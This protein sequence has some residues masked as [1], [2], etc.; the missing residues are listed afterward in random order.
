MDIQQA[1]ALIEGGVRKDSH[2]WAD[3]GAGTGT[4]TLALRELL[5]EGRIIA[6]DKNPHALFKLQREYPGFEIVEGDFTRP[7]EL[8]Q[9]DGMLMANAL[10]YAADPLPVLRHVLQY[11]KP[12][13]TFILVEY[14]IVSPVRTWVPYPVP[15]NLFVGL[16]AECGLSEVEEL[17]ALPSIYGNGRIY[18]LSALK[19]GS[20][21]S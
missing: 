16:A 5:P 6:L 4:F 2:S 10:H 3:I 17:G 14:D 18:A 7:M 21:A 19:T 12:G 11:L 8:P 1:I 15:M 13:G 9:L 20:L